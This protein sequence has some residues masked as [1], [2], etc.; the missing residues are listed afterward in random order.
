[1]HV[2][3]DGVFVQ[4]RNSRRGTSN[5]AVTTLQHYTIKLSTEQT[6]TPE[7]KWQERAKNCVKMSLLTKLIRNEVVTTGILW[8]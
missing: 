4:A 1:M 2:N 7:S 5:A 3:D 8:V 6:V